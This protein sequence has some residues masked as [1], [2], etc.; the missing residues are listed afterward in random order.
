M[1]TMARF[2]TEVMES[3]K[4]QYYELIW[5]KAQQHMF[6]T[7]HMQLIRK[8]KLLIALQGT[9]LSLIASRIFLGTLGH[10]LTSPDTQPRC[11]LKRVSPPLL[12]MLQY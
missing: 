7:E 2:S 4:P 10:C 11:C 3:S 9:Y 5:T 6:M 1:P 12:F 8:G